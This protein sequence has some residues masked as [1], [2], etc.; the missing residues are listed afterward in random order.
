MDEMRFT[1]ANGLFKPIASLSSSFW[2]KAQRRPPMAEALKTWI[3]PTSENWV[4]PETIMMTPA[5]MMAMMV[6]SFKV[7]LSSLKR[8]AK[9]RTKPSEDDLHIAGRTHQP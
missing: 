3:I 2:V 5:V 8:N 9:S 4:S 1:V 7:G 6:T